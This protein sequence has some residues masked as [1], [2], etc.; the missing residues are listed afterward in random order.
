MAIVFEGLSQCPLCGQI[1]DS[2]KEFM[3][4]PPLTSNTKDPLFVFG[5]AGLHISCLNK[6]PLKE[7]LLYHIERG[8]KVRVAANYICAVDGKLISVPEDILAFGM[9]TSDLNEPLAEFNFIILNRNNRY[10][11]NKRG[12]FISLVEE[13][14]RSGKWESYGPFNTL[15]YFVEKLA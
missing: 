9:L 1:L 2:S 5:D 10:K 3:L 12:E 7:S 13:F 15:E 6:H 14:I 4:T 11:W 8:D